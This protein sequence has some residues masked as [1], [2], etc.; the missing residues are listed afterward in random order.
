MVE[1]VFKRRGIA[2]DQGTL[3][4][5]VEHEAGQDEAEPCH[6]DRHLPEMAHVGVERFGPGDGE[7]D[8]TQGHKRLPAGSPNRPTA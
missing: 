6:P 8:R 7:H 1:R 2:Q 5:I 3:A 4:E